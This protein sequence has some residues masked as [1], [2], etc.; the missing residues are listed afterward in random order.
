LLLRKKATAHREQGQAMIL[1][2]IGRPKVLRISISGLALGKAVWSN[3]LGLRV[4][5]QRVT[6]KMIQKHNWQR[7]GYEVID[8]SQ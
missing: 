2:L 4:G 8:I 3:V 7:T 5:C 1:E 6:T